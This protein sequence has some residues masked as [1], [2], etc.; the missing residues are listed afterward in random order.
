MTLD[1][2]FGLVGCFRNLEREVNA[3]FFEREEAIRAAIL[4]LMMNEHVYQIGQ[5]GT[6]K[7]LLIRTLAQR[8]SGSFFFETLL[9]GEST[10]ESL[11]G[12]TGR[13]SLANAH[14]VFLDEVFRAPK[15]LLFSLL[16]A[17]NERI[18][19]DGGPRRLPLLSLFAAS[20]Q[21]PSPA[22]GLDAFYD[23]FTFRS[24]VRPIER[25]ENFQN[26]MED[27]LPDTFHWGDPPLPVDSLKES[28]SDIRRLVEFDVRGREAIWHVRERFSQ[29]GIWL[30]DRRWKKVWNAAKG[31][32]AYAFSERVREIHI[33]ELFPVLWTYPT[34]FRTIERILLEIS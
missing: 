25:K 15:S 31:A 24:L 9:N 3:L 1:D 34:E 5:P 18:I 11:S 22:D 14:I 26:Y 30:S 6:G 16:P 7:S 29:E 10:R 23:R 33:R 27:H 20:N 19:Y 13:Q 2:L 8:V 21:N 4:A 12:S 28:G 32:A 17:L